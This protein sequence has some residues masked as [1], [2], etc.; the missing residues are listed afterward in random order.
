MAAKPKPFKPPKTLGECADLLGKLKAD[1]AAANK[2]VDAIHADRVALSEHI[3][4]NLPKSKATGVSGR[5]WNAKVVSKII[6]QVR[7]WPAFWAW[8]RKT[9][10]EDV[11][12]KRLNDAAIK[13]RWEADKIVPGVEAFT[14]VVVSLTK[15]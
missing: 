2:I 5:A 10:S 14:A 7:D 15:I 13:E 1:E 8:I 9:Q 4:A 3:I 11:L 6:P 12:Q